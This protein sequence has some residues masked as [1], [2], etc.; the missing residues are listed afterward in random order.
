MQSKANKRQ[1]VWVLLIA[2][3]LIA[4]CLGGLWTYIQSADAETG[5]TET[6]LAQIPGED[7]ITI[8]MEKY[9]NFPPHQ[10]TKGF[11]IWTQGF[12]LMQIEKD[13]LEAMKEA[14]ANGARPKEPAPTLPKNNTLAIL[15]LDPKSFDGETEYYFLP[16]S[17]LGDEQ[18]LQL[19]DYGEKTGK[20]F[21]AETLTVKNSM[22]GSDSMTSRQFSSG[23]LGRYTNLSQR[24]I[25]EGLERPEITDPDPSKPL[26]GIA[27]IPMNTY[28]YGIEMFALYPLRELTDEELLQ[29]FYT[30]RMD[31]GIT[32]LNPAEEADLNPA[33]D[34]QRIRALLTDIM[35]MPASAKMTL[36]GYRHMDATGEVRC[37][38]TFESARIN[39]KKTDYSVNID[40]A[41]WTPLY[42]DQYV[43]D[44]A[45][46][47]DTIDVEPIPPNVDLHDTR[48]SDIA[49]QAV[50]KCAANPIDRAEAEGFSY[51]GNEGQACTDISVILKNCDTYHV[52]V[53]LSDGMVFTVQ[54]MHK[55]QG[56]ADIT[57]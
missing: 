49:T 8:T 34:A 10:E 9:D 6:S 57:W 45:Y 35:Q 24:A 25:Q 14:Y 40:L 42:L 47:V 22:R 5:V 48:W 32:L 16:Q 13:R 52:V 54:L 33:D 2:F 27:Y 18:L 31:K 43:D 37:Y 26:S 12:G 30:L 29:D 21:S 46:P 11:R 56:E 20:P 4:L 50:A 36:L 28:A 15:P 17:M 51:I 23:E 3:V 55:G 53:R 38:A 41:A 1:T 44:L 39:G 7:E 19:I